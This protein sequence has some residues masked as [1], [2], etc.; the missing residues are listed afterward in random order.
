MMDARTQAV[1]A[2]RLD[3]A[4]DRAGV[5]V[6]RA[7]FTGGNLQQWVAVPAAAI[8]GRLMALGGWRIRIV[9]PREVEVIDIGRAR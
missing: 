8:L 6:E 9:E 4:M 3:E 2:G 7:V 5:V 1:A